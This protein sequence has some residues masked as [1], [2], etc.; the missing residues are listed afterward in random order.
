[1]DES[2]AENPSD[3]V[4]DVEVTLV[5]S[6]ANLKI[7]ANRRPKQLL[8]I[9]SGLNSLGFHVLHLNVTTADHKIL[10]TFSLKVIGAWHSL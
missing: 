4:A 5:D 10:Y 3:A 2:T 8:K 1:M 6:H 7:M 9:I